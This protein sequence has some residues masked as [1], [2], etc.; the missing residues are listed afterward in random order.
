MHLPK[1]GTLFPMKP[2]HYHTKKVNNSVIQYPYTNILNY[3]KI[4]FQN[5]VVHSISLLCLFSSLNLQELYAPS[6]VTCDINYSNSPGQSTCR[7][8]HF[9]DV[10]HCF[11]SIKFR[12]NISDK[13]I[14]RLGIFPNALDH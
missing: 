3:L 12:S 10:S 6:L 7:T 11:P 5:P 8:S 2:Y 9:L 13:S 4:R 14:S 1:R